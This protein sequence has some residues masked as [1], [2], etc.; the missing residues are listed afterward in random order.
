MIIKGKKNAIAETNSQ[1]VFLR[2]TNITI[3]IP[4]VQGSWCLF[5]CFDVI[6]KG[7]T[8]NVRTKPL[9]YYVRFPNSN[10]WT[11]T[12]IKYALVLGIAILIYN[13]YIANKLLNLKK[14]LSGKVCKNNKVGKGMTEVIYFDAVMLYWLPLYI[15]LQCS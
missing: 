5:L 1:K 6:S 2:L 10:R 9:N 15:C 7:R 13:L 3:Y 12:W 4:D 11:W 14:N 8:T